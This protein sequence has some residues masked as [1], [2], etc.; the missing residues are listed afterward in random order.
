MNTSHPRPIRLLPSTLRNQIAAGEVVERPAS[1]LKELLENSI[2]AQAKNIAVSLEDGGQTLLSLK[3]DG[4]GIPSEDME[5]AITRHATSKITS[6]EEL[7]HIA[8][9]GFRGEALPSIASVAH[10]RVESAYTQDHVSHDGAF[11]EVS[12]GNIEKK[13]PSSVHKGTIVTVRDL[14]ANVPARLKFLKTP[15]TELKRCQEIF[16]RLAIAKPDISFSF[17]SGGKELIRMPAG[18]DITQR[19]AKIWPPQIIE[20]MVSFSATRHDVAVHGL[21]SLP[22]NAQA[23]GDRIFLYVNGRPVNDKLLLGAVRTAYKGMLTSREY[24]QLVLFVDVDPAEVDVNTHPSKTEVRFREERQVFSAVLTTLQNAIHKHLSIAGGSIPPLQEQSEQKPTMHGEQRTYP[25]LYTPTEKKSE[26]NPLL[27]ET[28]TPR[29]PRPQGFWGSIENPRIMPFPEKKEREESFDEHVI[30]FSEKT[31]ILASKE[32]SIPPF[33]S[34]FS[35]Q[36]TSVQETNSTFISKESDFFPENKEQPATFF[37]NTSHIQAKGSLLHVGFPVQVESLLCIGQI[38][39]TYLIIKE[40]EELLLLDQH[41]AHERILVNQ[42]ES[43]N[44]QGRSQL[45]VLHQEI[46]LHP[47]EE[48]RFFQCKNDLT[49]MGF[50]LELAK[51]DTQSILSVQGVPPLLSH[52]QSMQMLKDI[53][54]DRMD[55]FDDIFHMMSCRAA[56][57]AGQELT[58]DEAATLLTQWLHTPNCHFCP[59]GRPIAL[60]LGSKELEKMFKR[61]I[62]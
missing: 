45:L 11:L 34:P 35:S 6:F 8:S 19:L 38:A 58:A 31:T 26:N 5:L 55:G 56:I 49:Q 12:F 61:K 21:A 27:G 37:T 60:R 48:E 7:T 47:S 15:A 1:V 42:I 53:L 4:Y 44:T 14:F 33:S 29:S 57:K 32:E 30:S 39:K 2:D 36:H 46:H 9:Y 16:I 18:L 22:Q 54:A 25:P 52:S 23:K 10:V 20:G 13:G 51:K 43:G 17:S 24:P 40:G 3:D 28:D 59:H 41:A 62:S 50:I